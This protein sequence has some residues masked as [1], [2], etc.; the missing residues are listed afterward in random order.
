[1]SSCTVCLYCA[2]FLLQTDDNVFY[3]N[4]CFA[5]ITVKKRA[6]G[7]L[8]VPWGVEFERNGFVLG[9]NDR[10]TE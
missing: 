1:M 6:D 7:H 3:F 4:S 9:G 2:L 5:G 8:F 10:M